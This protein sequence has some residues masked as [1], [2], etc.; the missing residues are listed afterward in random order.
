MGRS[1]HEEFGVGNII[2]ATGQESV[3]G[4]EEEGRVAKLTTDKAVG[5]VQNRPPRNTCAFGW[6]EL[7]SQL[8]A[9]GSLRE[10]DDSRPEERHFPAYVINWSIF[11]LRG[12]LSF[13]MPDPFKPY[14]Q[15]VQA[16]LVG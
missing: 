7:T 2:T 6:G 8:L 15:E 13:P 11:Q 1:D 12:R 4:G 14:V 9:C 5:L 10:P 3:L 16:S